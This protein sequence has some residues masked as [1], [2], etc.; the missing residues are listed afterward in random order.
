MANDCSERICQFGLAHVDTPK[1]DLDSSSGKLSGPSTESS[2]VVNDAMYPKGTTEQY[3][4]MVDSDNIIMD[5]SAHEYRECSNKGICDRASGDCKCFDGYHGSA[6]QRAHCPVTGGL[7]CSGHGTC[8]TVKE[9]AANDNNNIYNLWD[10]Y[11][12]MGCN[13]Q[14]A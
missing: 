6:C 10:E 14:K 11:S 1:G 7:V 5:N 9:I 3:P 13:F 4:N 2:V 8:E 12:T